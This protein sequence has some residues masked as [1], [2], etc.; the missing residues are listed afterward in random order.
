MFRHPLLLALL[1]KE[2]RHFL[3]S[4]SAPLLLLI[5]LATLQF[6]FFWMAAWF[7]R[8][9]A[10]MRPMFEI[11]PLLFI[12]LCSA[13]TMKSWSEEK[14]L[15][16]LDFLSTLPAPL[17]VLMAGKFFAQLQWV[18][19]ALLLT[20]P[21][22][23]SLHFS[24]M[25]LDWGPI[26][27]GYVAS[28]LLASAYLAIGHFASART[29]N[30]MTA[31]FT[32]VS[33]GALLYLIG[34]PTITSVFSVEVAS[35][36]RALAVGE[37]F[38]SIA[39]GVMDIRDIIYYAS[40]TLFFLILTWDRLRRDRW[41]APLSLCRSANATKPM[42]HR[43]HRVMVALMIANVLLIHSWLSPWGQAARIDLTAD[44]RFSFSPYSKNILQ[45]LESPLLI[46][47]YFSHKTHPLI[48]PLQ[49]ELIDRLT[50]L[51]RLQPRQVVLE[52]FDPTQTPEWE[53]EAHSRYRISPLPFRFNDRYEASVVSAYFHLV[54]QTGE[55]HRVLSVRELL[56]FK[57]NADGRV[58]VLLR[59]PEYELIR[60]IREVT[61]RQLGNRHKIALLVPPTPTGDPTWVDANASGLLQFS[62]LEQALSEAH[63]LETITYTGALLEDTSAFNAVVIAAPRQLSPESAEALQEFH[64]RGGHIVLLTSPFQPVLTETSLGIQVIESALEPWLASLGMRLEKSMVLDPINVPFPTMTTRQL[65]NGYSVPEML[66]A[67]YPYFINLLTTPVASPNRL[68]ET[69]MEGLSALIVPWAVPINIAPIEGYRATTL[70]ESSENS[71]LSAEV[72][73]VPQLDGAGNSDFKPHD[74]RGRYPLAV[75]LEPTEVNTLRGKIVVIGANAFASDG[76]QNLISLSEGQLNRQALQWMQNLTD[77]LLGDNG[78]HSIRARHVLG[79]TLPP[80]LPEQKRWIEWGN[81]GLALLSIVALLIGGRWRYHRRQRRWQ[82]AFA[83]V[84]ESPPTHSKPSS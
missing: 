23:I 1:D 62:A 63:D 35:G 59:N 55:Y 17:P 44:R 8:N 68:P 33:I 66:L 34:S 21:L 20:V 39:R 37:R 40:L 76:V 13:M 77:S 71:W 69:L 26:V 61:D 27:G 48:A 49:S 82:N 19:I 31:L 32:S 73:V 67:P 2:R 43:A 83:D 9:V 42:T 50:E 72:D 53:E 51:A 74:K 79:K 12:F 46:R 5:F 36:M 65:D 11:F 80:L 70:L 29:D 3:Y 22:P 78:L 58:E 7:S 10:D 14:R 6:Y 28:L 25:P 18:A 4:H 60:T 57:T 15:G 16:T 81:E 64:R 41:A 30:P 56:D 45:E 47:A 52:R 54:I 75:S 84:A 38:S 24:V